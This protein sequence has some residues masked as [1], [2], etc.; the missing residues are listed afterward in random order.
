MGK[1]YPNEPAF[2][3]KVRNLAEVEAAKNATVKRLR[4]MKADGA[5]GSF[6]Y[7]CGDAD[8]AE[9]ISLTL[10]A[11]GI[12]PGLIQQRGT[13]FLVGWKHTV[14]ELPDVQEKTGALVAVA[15]PAMVNS[16]VNFSRPKGF[17]PRG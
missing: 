11:M 17:A 8:T 5:G 4:M 1:R 16:A 3:M 7:L 13:V 2:R 6:R 14:N 12:S 10:R 15:T 9:M